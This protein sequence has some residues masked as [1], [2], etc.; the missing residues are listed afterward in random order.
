MKTELRFYKEVNKGLLKN[1]RRWYADV[2]NWTGDKSALEMVYGADVLLDNIAKGRDEVHLLFS[3]DIIQDADYLIFKHKTPINGA[4][5]RLKYLDG[6]N[7]NKK[8]WLCDV[9]KFVMGE[10]PKR[11]YFKE[12]N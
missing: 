9:L 8:V 3:S 5:Y 1:S 10:F 7:Y 12:I 6:K 11:I 2:L 4:M